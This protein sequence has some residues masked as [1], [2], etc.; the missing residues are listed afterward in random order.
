MVNRNLSNLNYG[1]TL[2]VDRNSR[3]DLTNV[4]YPVGGWLNHKFH[5]KIKISRISIVSLGGYTLAPIFFRKKKKTSKRA[6]SNILGIPEIFNLERPCM[7]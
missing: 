4:I 2:S 5:C 7:I 6:I 3:Y 1:G